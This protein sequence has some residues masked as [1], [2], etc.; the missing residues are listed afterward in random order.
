MK[1]PGERD[2]RQAWEQ[3]ERGDWL[4]WLAEKRRVDRKLLVL[5]AC[6]CARLALPHVKTGELRPLKAIETAEA[7]SAG[8]ATKAEVRA[9][10]HAAHA[11][12]YAATDA[13]YAYAA[14][15][16]AYAAHAAHA[17]TDA[18]YAYAAYAA[19]YAA[20]AHAYCAAE[21]RSRVLK[22]CA[23]I[24]RAQIDFDLVRVK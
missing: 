14:Y 22:V 2:E 24:V 23:D 17:A 20:A 9:A 18:A 19:A 16:A 10:A 3:C 7:W 5:A 8:T 1:W 12:A 6:K 11:A 21:A 13:A 15:A 4:L